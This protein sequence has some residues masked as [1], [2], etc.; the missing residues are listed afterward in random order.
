M[1]SP[2]KHPIL[3]SHLARMKTSITALCMLASIATAVPAALTI[4]QSSVCQDLLYSV[5]Y[6]CDAPEVL[7]PNQLDCTTR[8][9]GWLSSPSPSTLRKECVLLEMLTDIIASL[10]SSTGSFEEFQN[11]CAQDGKEAKCASVP[12]E[13]GGDAVFI[14]AI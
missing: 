11:S 6:C 8:K 5:P 14:D 13:D 7:N 12:T 2:T 1:P 3:F 10:A 9:F 4:R